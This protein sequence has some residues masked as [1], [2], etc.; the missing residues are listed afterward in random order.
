MERVFS[1]EEI[2]HPF[3]TPTP[4]IPGGGEDHHMKRSSS[5][6]AFQRFLQEAV[7]SPTNSLSSSTSNTVVPLFPPSTLLPSSSS[8]SPDEEV[9]EI[10]DN[11][12]HHHIQNHHPLPS[13]DPLLKSPIDAKEYQEILK[14]RLTQACAAV[15]MSRVSTVKSQDSTTFPNTG[16]QVSDALPLESQATSK[17]FGYKFSSVQNKAVGGG[18]VGIPALPAVQKISGM[19]VRPT[20]SGS[21]REQSD[22][23]D[24]EGETEMTDNMDPTDVKRVRRMLSNRESARRSRRRKQAHLSELEGQVAQLRLE[25]SSL[26][27]RLT[28]INHK[29]TEAAVDNRVLKADVETVRAKVKMAEETVKRMTGLSNPLFQ[30]MPDFSNMGMPY[31]SSPTLTDSSADVSAPPRGGRLN[32]GLAD[33]SPVPSGESMQNN[34]MGPAG[35]P[36]QWDAGWGGGPTNPS[37]S[38]ER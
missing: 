32:N 18:P 6:W 34:K 13:S 9:I 29:Y 3:W 22:D 2:S 1:V 24:L 23:D 36:V 27:K 38:T 17:G 21:S 10:K 19:P 15:A 25:N 8:R 26:L 14:Q 33:S 16:V 28:D 4:Q 35:G 20:T 12:N 30:A 37:S 31:V 11:H 7:T 5:E